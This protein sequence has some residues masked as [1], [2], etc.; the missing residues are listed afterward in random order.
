MGVRVWHLRGI[1][2]LMSLLEN[3]FVLKRM[4]NISIFMQKHVQKYEDG[5]AIALQKLYRALNQCIAT[6]QRHEHLQ[7]KLTK[8]A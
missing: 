2:M 5:I 1:F 4:H 3:R 8:I 7:Q 6:E